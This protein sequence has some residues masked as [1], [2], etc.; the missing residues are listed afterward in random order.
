MMGWITSRS[1][2]SALRIIPREKLMDMRAKL[3]RFPQR[4]SNH[5]ENFLLACKGEEAV[6][7]PFSV[8]AP[9]TQVFNLGIIAQMFG[10]ELRFDRATQQIVS[11]ERASAI[12]DPA[13]R[14][15]WE[16]FYRMHL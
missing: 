9:L 7:S 8:G 15:G 1:H 12:M 6:R 4:N 16:E 11:D 10:G 3:P 14:A 13:P 2:G 5:Y